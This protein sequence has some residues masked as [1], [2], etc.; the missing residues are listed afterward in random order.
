[1]P[2]L[3]LALALVIAAAAA[4][5]V[6]W[7]GHG[8]AL[9]GQRV[10]RWGRWARGARGPGG[11]VPAGPTR[12]TALVMPDI[13]GYTRFL[14]LSRFAEAHAQH[15]VT[16]L[17]QAIIAGAA[18]TLTAAKVEGDAV[19]LYAPLEGPHARTPE[20]IAEAVERLMHAFYRRVDELARS[21]LCHCACCNHL[22]DLD[23]KAVIHR[24]PVTAYRLGRFTELSGMPVILTHR[25]LKNSARTPR[26][27]LVTEEARAL[28]PGFA[29][30]GAATVEQSDDLGP[31]DCRLISFDRQ[32]VAPPETGAQAAHPVRE[33][34]GK[35]AANLRGLWPARGGRDRA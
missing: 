34:A 5:V 6:H 1:M 20:Q 30:N 35:L 19:L 10:W 9:V 7:R 22:G 13:S 29:G 14:H 26:Y 21:N 12:D 15:I 25:L 33:T 27:L 23:I 2:A 11:T 24:G 16:E 28:A 18:P 4:F 17:L 32:D 8:H 31:V 3:V